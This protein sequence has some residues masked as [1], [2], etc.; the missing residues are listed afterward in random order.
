MPTYGEDGKLAPNSLAVNQV[1]SSEV[2][3]TLKGIIKE[4][5]VG[6]WEAA[7]NELLEL[8]AKSYKR[9]YGKAK[10]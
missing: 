1:V 5:P 6:G 3:E 2:M 7:I 10:S 9:K 8:G 4:F